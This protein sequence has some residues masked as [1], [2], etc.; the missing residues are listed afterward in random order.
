MQFREIV[1]HKREI[2]RLVSMVDKA[3]IPHA[4]LLF[5]QSGIGK[6]NVARALTQYMFCLDRRDGDSCGKCPNCLQTSKLNNPDIHYVFPIIKK[7]KTDTSDDFM[8]EWKEFT[9]AYPYSS[10]EGWLKILNAGNSRPLIHVTE[11]EQ[12]IRKSTLSSYGDKYKVFVV[13]LPEKM[14]AEAANRLLK[15]VEEPFE[16]TFFIFVSNSPS[17]ILPTILSRLQS[18][19][20]KALSNQDIKSFLIGKGKSQEEADSLL[21]LIKGNMNQALQL[22]NENGEMVEFAK[23]FIEVMRAAYSRKMTNLRDLSESFAAYGREKSIRFLEYFTR[24][25]R[26]SFI[27]NLRI[28]SIEAMTME[29]KS[30]VNKFGPFINEANIEELV[31]HAARAREDISRNAN[32]KIV[33]FD[34]FIEL[35]RLIRTK[36]IK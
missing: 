12:L 15:L 28:E 16:D 4:L 1:G 14:N 11:S 23:A 24:M 36:G 13:W 31:M 27:S 3:Q 29:E 21:K 20:F 30:F 18:V 5:G 2:E 26:E 32:Q 19:E 10:P 35:T 33:W 6:M 25:F 7:D 34:F 17:E 8:E 9:E 22:I